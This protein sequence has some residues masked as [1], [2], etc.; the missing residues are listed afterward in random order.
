MKAPIRYKAFLCLVVLVMIIVGSAGCGSTGETSSPTPTQTTD[1]TAEVNGLLEEING[2]TVLRIWGSRQEMGYAYGY[3]LADQLV[4]L[5]EQY[6]FDHLIG[7]LDSQV[8]YDT[9]V[10]LMEQSIY[11]PEWYVEEMEAMVEGIKDALGGSLPVITHERIEGGSRVLEADMLALMNS[12]RDLI[13]VTGGQSDSCS[14][15]A[16]WGDVTGD[17]ET[18]VAGNWDDGRGDVLLQEHSLLIVRKPDYGYST[19]SSGFVGMV[20]ISRGMNETGVV[21]VPQGCDDASRRVEVTGQCSPAV[22][23]RDVLESQAARPDLVTRITGLFKGYPPMCGAAIILF[24]QGKPTWD[25]PRDN[26][27]ALVI[28]SDFDGVTPRLP[29][30]NVLYGN[31]LTEAIVA[32]NHYLRRDY[33]SDYAPSENSVERYEAIMGV[34]ESQVIDGVSAMQDVLRACQQPAITKHSVYLEPDSKMIHVAFR[35]GDDPSSAEMTP[36]SFHWDDLFAPIPD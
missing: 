2:V 8:T 35:T 9:L 17:G 3:L 31:E 14:G 23:A 13:D 24:A 36:V 1:G 32:T 16:A 28:E 29:S 20:G 18:R 11:W 12:C 15:F 25:N 10:D 30:H 7:G 6:L 22:I 19:V 34:L 4:E 26:Q 27:M 21:T 33:P 5:I